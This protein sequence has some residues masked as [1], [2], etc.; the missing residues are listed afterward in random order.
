MFYYIKGRKRLINTLTEDELRHAYFSCMERLGDQAKKIKEDE[1][2]FQTLLKLVDHI[3]RE[4]ERRQL[5]V[6][7][8]SE[9]IQ[10]EI[11]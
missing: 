3:S 5:P 1:K 6:F 7:E 2:K 9:V 10:L 8:D 4:A 11:L